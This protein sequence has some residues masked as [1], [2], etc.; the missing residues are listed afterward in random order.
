MASQQEEAART[1]RRDTL[2]RLAEFFEVY[3]AALHDVSERYIVG[4]DRRA[5]TDQL[6]DSIN[7]YGATGD[8]AAL[9]DLR[10]C[11]SALGIDAPR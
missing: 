2:E 8:E 11:A 9:D 7:R 3:A 1:R 10:A 5:V 4:V 6:L